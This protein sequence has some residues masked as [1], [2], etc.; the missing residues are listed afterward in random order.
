VL[1]GEVLVGK[2]AAVDALAARAVAGREVAALGHE[3]GDDAVEGAALEV[4]GLARLAHALLAGAEGA[5]VL[6]RRGGGVGAELELDAAEV[7][8]VHG[9]V[10]ED[11]GVGGGGAGH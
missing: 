5:E 10:E 4:Q 6:G 8:V 7:L 1:D 3:P 2:R 11:A 9:H